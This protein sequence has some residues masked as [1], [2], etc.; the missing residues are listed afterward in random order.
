MKYLKNIDIS[1]AVSLIIVRMNNFQLVFFLWIFHFDLEV[2]PHNKI[3][4]YCFLYCI[5]VCL[6]LITYFVTTGFNN[7]LDHTFF[8]INL[9][10]LHWFLFILVNLCIIKLIF[11]HNYW[12]LGNG[13]FMKRNQNKTMFLMSYNS[14]S[15]NDM[16][17]LA[18]GVSRR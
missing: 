10:E 2:K 9:Y 17:F 7:I 11:W 12:F 18:Y 3:V 16:K 13:F 5:N 1:L 14:S 15:F 4:F 6:K 8:V